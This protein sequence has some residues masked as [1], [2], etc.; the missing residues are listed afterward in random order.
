VPKVENGYISG[1]SPM[2]NF[3]ADKKEVNSQSLIL[4]HGSSLKM[5]QNERYPV[6]YKVLIQFFN[7]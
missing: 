5:S 2:T 7:D 4:I 1:I 3:V 6:G